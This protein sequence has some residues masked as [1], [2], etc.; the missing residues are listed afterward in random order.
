VWVLSKKTLVVCF[1]PLGRLLNAF[2]ACERLREALPLD[3]LTLLTDPSLVGLASKAP[4]FDDIISA[5]L[6]AADTNF[7]R[8][9]K[10]I[11]QSKYDRIIDLD[12]TA[13]TAK[14]FA[15]FGLFAPKFAGIAPRAKWSLISKPDHPVEEDARLLDL[16]G[17]PKTGADLSLGPQLSWLLRLSGKTPSLQPG[18]FRLEGDYILLNL[19]RPDPENGW[20]AAAFQTLA[21]YILNSGTMLAIT[22]SI[23]ARELA[24]PLI[25]NYPQIRDLCA[26]ADAFQLASL[27]AKAKGIVGL[28]DGIL[29]LCAASSGRCISLHGSALDAALTGIRSPNAMTLISDPLED[30]SADDVLRAMKMFGAL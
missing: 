1:G 26:R 11:K 22:G 3:N 20:P 15:A 9:A 10:A 16:M 5:D 25:R 21:G 30:L 13:R 2:C 8:L 27:G 14:L 18:Y 12:R 6:S 19:G 7:S 24:R 23:E 28:P 4:W 29:H 17:V